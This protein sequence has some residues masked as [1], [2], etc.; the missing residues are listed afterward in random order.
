MSNVICT[1]DRFEAIAKYK[2]KLLDKT[3]IETSADEMA[4]IDNILFRMWQ[5][6]WL[7]RLE[8]P[9]VDAVPVVRCEDCKHYKDGFCYNP[10]TYDDEKTCG[11]T[12]KDWFCADGERKEKTDEQQT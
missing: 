7:D 5:I 12:T 10:N 4:V 11:N 8:Q 2:A 6:G 9:T 3:N 1:D